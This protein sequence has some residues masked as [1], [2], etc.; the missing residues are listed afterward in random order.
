MKISIII[1]WYNEEHTIQQVI[2]MV[3]N[4]L[5]KREYEI[6]LVDDA[7]TDN[8]VEIIEEF[9]KKDNVIRFFKNE[10]NRG[11]FATWS[12]NVARNTDS[13]FVSR[14]CFSARARYSSAVSTTQSL[15]PTLRRWLAECRPA[16]V[17]PIIAIIGTPIHSA[18]N[19]V[20]RSAGTV[21]GRSR[22][23][24]PSSTSS[25]RKRR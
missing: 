12:R 7:S 25:P 17:C 23:T 2:R 11:D 14:L 19:T 24:A 9:A 21:S 16:K 1:P 22:L 10:K 3:Q 18:S 4:V 5:E 15:N 8:S 13:F 20:F 6:I